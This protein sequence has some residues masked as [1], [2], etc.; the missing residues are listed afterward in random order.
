VAI[1]RALV[2]NPKLILADEPTGAL[3][4]RIGSEILAKLKELNAHG[5]TIIMVTHDPELARHADRIVVLLDG[6]IAHESVAQKV[7]PAGREQPQF[8]IVE[9]IGRGA[10]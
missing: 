3:D 10:D 2:N 7:A 6:R 9:P 1:A 8:G 5:R 4:R